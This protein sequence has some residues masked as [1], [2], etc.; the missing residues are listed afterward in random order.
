M[1]RLHPVFKSLGVLAL[2]AGIA[3]VVQGSVP[4]P[5]DGDSMLLESRTDVSFAS[6]IKPILEESCVSCHGGTF[7]GQ[8]RTEL[9]LNLTTYEGVI[10]G[11]EYGPVI[12]P[13]E[14]DESLLLEMIEDGD[15]PEEGDLLSA[16]AIEKI[17][18]W[19]AEGAQKN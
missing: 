11:S 1:K 6:Q 12:E 10:A 5:S 19:I 13:G 15:M 17:R 8:P 4:A 16:E 14:P 2:P 3:L 7:E 9:S 18:T